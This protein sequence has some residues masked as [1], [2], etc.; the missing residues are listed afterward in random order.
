MNNNDVI[1]L[2]NQLVIMKALLETV[3]DNNLKLELKSHIVLTEGRL[4]AYSQL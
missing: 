1:I 4:N 3:K 2:M